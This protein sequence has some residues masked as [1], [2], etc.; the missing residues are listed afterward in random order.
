MMILELDNVIYCSYTFKENQKVLMVE[1]RGDL[2]PKLNHHFI[3]NFDVDR[4]IFSCEGRQADIT[5]DGNSL[6]N[7]EIT[8]INVL[9][10]A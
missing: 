8:T 1:L 4:K 2:Y 9:E 10:I 6:N 3:R 5:E 7:D